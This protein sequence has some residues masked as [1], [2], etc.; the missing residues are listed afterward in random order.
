MKALILAGG[1]GTRLRGIVED[2]PKS[3]ALVSDTPFLE[4][5]I[6]QLG[7]HGLTDIVLCIGYLGEQI[8]RYF[9]D[10]GRWGVHISYSQEKEPLGTAG[11]VKLAEGLIKDE[12]FLVMNGDSF[13]REGLFGE[14]GLPRHDRQRVLR[15]A[16]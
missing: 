15:D 1:L 10:G 12:N 2:R 6:L 7:R 5:L 16:G 13:L 11:A 8:K 4:C 3:M 14:G 9:D